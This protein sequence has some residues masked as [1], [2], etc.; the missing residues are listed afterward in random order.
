MPLWGRSRRLV[1][2]FVGGE[3]YFWETFSSN[4]G[5]AGTGSSQQ[6]ID[7]LLD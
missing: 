3:F 2:T 1:L 6:T 7:H 4:T 5:L